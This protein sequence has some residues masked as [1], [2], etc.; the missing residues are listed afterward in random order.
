MT[1]RPKIY[2][3]NTMF[4]CIQLSKVKGEFKRGTLVIWNNLK[5]T[6][7]VARMFFIYMNH[8]RLSFLHNNSSPL[9]V[10]VNFLQARIFCYL[11]T[12]YHQI[13]ETYLDT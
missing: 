12:Y 1:D 2:D 3:T 11:I 5:L 10:L 9:N 4:T 6:I 8:V 13:Q 7:K